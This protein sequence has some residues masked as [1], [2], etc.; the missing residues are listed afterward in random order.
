M[1]V[2]APRCL[3]HTHS[4]ARLRHRVADLARYSGPQF[5]CHDNSKSIDV[6][7][8]NDD[9]CDCADGSDEPGTSACSNGSFWCR[10]RG[11]V[12]R[13]IPSSMVHDNICG[14]CQML[15]CTGAAIVVVVGERALLTRGARLRSSRLLRWQRRGAWGVPARLRQAGRRTA[16]GEHKEAARHPRGSARSSALGGGGPCGVPERR[17]AAQP[18]PQGRH[19]RAREDPQRASRFVRADAATSRSPLHLI[20]EDACAVPCRVVSCCV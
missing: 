3:C 2:R 12:G 13:F 9:Y 8:V 19:R 4:Q 17:A 10:N 7:K 6:K 11:H 5:R 14:A 20:D 1:S 18:E 16:P 15:R